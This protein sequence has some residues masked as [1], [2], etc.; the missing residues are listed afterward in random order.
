MPP[1]LIAITLAI[2]RDRRPD[3]TA[4]PPLPP[5][6]PRPLLPPI[7]VAVLFRRSLRSRR[8]SPLM[9]CG[10]TP[11][12]VTAQWRGCML[13]PPTYTL[14][15]RHALRSRLLSTPRRALRPAPCPPLRAVLFAPATFS[16]PTAPAAPLPTLAALSAHAALS[17]PAAPAAPAMPPHPRTR[18]TRRSPPRALRSRAD[19]AAP[20]ELAA[21][22]APDAL[23]DPVHAH[24][25]PHAHT[26]PHTP[27]LHA[28]PAHR[29]RAH[30]PCTHTT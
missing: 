29:T 1:R 16:A 19:L 11:Q 24:T 18:R 28:A 7:A 12:R 23:S 22:A 26:G 15:S 8:R 9:A 17:A 5:H 4:A 25:R 6:S 10:A 3:A 14:R 13:P 2:C 21:P 30:T 27:C 20:V